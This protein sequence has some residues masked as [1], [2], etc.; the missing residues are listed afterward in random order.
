MKAA[1]DFIDKHCDVIDDETTGGA[2]ELSAG[3]KALRGLTAFLAKY[4]ESK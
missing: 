3:E 4:G 2:H 1:R